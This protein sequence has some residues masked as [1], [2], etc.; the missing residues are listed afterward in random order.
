MGFCAIIFRPRIPLSARPKPSPDTPKRPFFSVA[1]F[2]DSLFLRL[3]LGLF[4]AAWAFPSPFF[5]P[6]YAYDM[7]LSPQM[8]SN[9]LA[10]NG[11]VGS[12][13]SVVVGSLVHRAGSLNLLCLM[14]ALTALSIFALWVPAG[15]SEAMLYAFAVCWGLFWGPLFGLVGTNVAKLFA[16]IEAFPVAIGT[17]YVAFSLAFFGNAPLFGALVD[18]GAVYIDGV[19]V[20][21]SYLYAQLWAGCIYAVGVCFLVWVRMSVAGWKMLVKV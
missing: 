11:G 16:R 9:L 13:S 8:G 14:Q 3:F 1:L 15:T 10:I 19:K 4:L 6:S 17:L 18:R 20:S 21:A 7:K 12:L 2:K 5:L